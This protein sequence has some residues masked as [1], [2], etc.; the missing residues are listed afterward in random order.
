MSSHP[1]VV[2][3]VEVEV[4]PNDL[5]VCLEERGGREPSWRGSITARASFITTAT[6]MGEPLQ[7]SCVASP[8]NFVPRKPMMWT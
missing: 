6:L 4:V 3:V 2:A 1:G 5:R 7:P 8:W